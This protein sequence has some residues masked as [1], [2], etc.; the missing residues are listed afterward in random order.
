MVFKLS[1]GKVVRSGV[2]FTSS[3]HVGVSKADCFSGTEG[4]HQAPSLRFISFYHIILPMV[5][6]KNNYY[7]IT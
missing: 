4:S 1:R 7:L 2:Y 6:P 3:L 5:A